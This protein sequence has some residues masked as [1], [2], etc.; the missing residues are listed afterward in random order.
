MPVLFQPKSE[1]AAPIFVKFIRKSANVHFKKKNSLFSQ[2]QFQWKKVKIFTFFQNWFD[3]WK[4][5][6]FNFLPKINFEKNENFQ[7]FLKINFWK[8]NSFFW[9]M[10]FW[11]N[12]NF[13]FFHKMMFWKNENFQFFRKNQLKF[14]YYQK[15]WLIIIITEISAS[16]DTFGIWHS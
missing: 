8:K 14:T 16:L 6:N 11:K 3:F 13:Q 4:S 9:K 7:F 1:A 2:N 12:E 15:F 10:I 5:K